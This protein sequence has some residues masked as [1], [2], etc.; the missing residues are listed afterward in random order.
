LRIVHVSTLFTPFVGGLEIAVQK[1]AEEQAKLGCEVCVITSDAH[2]KNRPKVEK[3]LI[4]VIRVRSLKNSYPYLIV[5]REIPKDI[6][7]SVDIVAGW[8]HTYYFNYKIIKAAKDLGKLVGMYFIGVDYLQHHYNLLFRVFGFQYQKILTKRLAEIVDMAFTTNKFERELLRNRYG[9]DSFV[10]PHGVDEIYLKSPN[11]AKQFRDKYAIDGRIV[12]YIGR[13]HPT[14]G[15]G[16]LIRAFAKV[17]KTELDLKL[18]IAGKGDTKYL[19][20]CLNIAR[21]LGLDDKV[22]YLGYIPEEDKIGLIDASELIVIPSK[23]AGES[24]PIIVDEVKARGKPLVVTNYGALP[25]RIKNMAEGIV[26]NADANS[27]ASG[28]KYVLKNVNAFKT[29]EKPCTWRDVAKKLLNLY[30]EMIKK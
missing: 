20:K 12:A 17:S 15:V 18:V 5:P 29:V 28:I 4:T 10:I 11:M 6:L 27:L 7:K 30:G 22:K 16:V 2:A 25:Y 8:G 9:L 19:E 26:V 23:H 13:I 3:G 24:Y 14:K 21:R 1:V